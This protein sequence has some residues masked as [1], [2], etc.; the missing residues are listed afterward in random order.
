M[1]FNLDD[2]FVEKATLE[3]NMEL[4]RLKSPINTQ[5]FLVNCEKTLSCARC[6]ENF[7]PKHSLGHWECSFHIGEF[8][9][10]CYPR[11][12]YTCCGKTDKKSKGCVPCDHHEEKLYFTWVD[13]IELTDNVINT[14]GA[15]VFDRI[16]G[17]S[18]QVANGMLYIVRYDVSRDT[19]G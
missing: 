16:P 4:M 17:D 13:H 18:K 8:N 9:N 7:V 11:P 3:E 10:L 2:A 12:A 19:F 15:S 1:P 6:K 14:L 5:Y